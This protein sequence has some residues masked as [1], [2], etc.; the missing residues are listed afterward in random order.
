MLKHP[1]NHAIC[2]LLLVI[3]SYAVSLVAAG[4]VVVYVAV[5]HLMKNQLLVVLLFMVGGFVLPAAAQLG[6]AT[7]EARVLE[8]P[9]GQGRRNHGGKGG[10]S[11]P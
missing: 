10:S 1:R 2:Q 7:I 11:P 5:L 9:Q 3:H 8:T 6:N 4:L